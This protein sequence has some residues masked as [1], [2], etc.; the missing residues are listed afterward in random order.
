MNQM[1]DFAIVGAGCSGLTLAS[2]M[3]VQVPHNTRIALVDLRT[4]YGMDRVWCYWNVFQH[5]FL[6]AVTH[7]WQRWKIRHRGREVVL[8]TNRYPYHFIPADAFYKMAFEKISHHGG[9]ELHLGKAVERFEME[10]GHVRIKTDSDDLIA[11]QV[12]DGRLLPDDL[13]GWQCLLQHYGGQII[14]ADRP[15]FDPETITLMDFDIS[16]KEG[17][18]FVYVLPFSSTRALIEPTFFSYR[19]LAPDDYKA[20]IRSYLLDRYQT[21]HYTV[22][23]EERGIIPMQSRVPN[24]HPLSRVHRI[25]TQAGMVK[26]STGYGFLAIQKWTPL[27]LKQHLGPSPSEPQ[28]P[29]TNF[30]RR[31]DAIFL[32]YIEQHPQQ[33]PEIF[34]NL[35]SRVQPDALVRFL[36]DIATPADIGAVIGAMPKWPFFRKAVELLMNRDKK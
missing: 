35:F 29:R 22:E 13:T 36:S 20:C 2:L 7:A 34:F 27:L 15:V 5:P 10:N 18:A 3:A 11:R 9:I 19:P 17:I 32:A 25:G 24:G 1:Y 30:S 6:D 12:F 14:A 31:L 21:S 23:F 33:A 16:Q 28:F 26:G 8:T 4:T